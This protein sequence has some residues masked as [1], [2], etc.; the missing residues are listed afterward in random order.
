MGL[1]PHAQAGM[2]KESPDHQQDPE[3]PIAFQKAQVRVNRKKDFK[4]VS[5]AET[6]VPYQQQQ[7]GDV[8]LN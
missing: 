7:P 6:E 8:I 5:K 4:P 2:G 1:E 3:S